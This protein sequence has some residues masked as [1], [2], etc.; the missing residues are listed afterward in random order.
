MNVLWPMAV[1]LLL[2]AARAQFEAASLKPDPG[3]SP[4]DPAD[5]TDRADQDLFVALREQI[6]A[7]GRLAGVPSGSGR[8]V[9]GLWQAA[10]KSKS[11]G[12]R[13]TPHGLQTVDS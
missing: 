2:P 13:P 6:G 8:L 5:A 12:Q 4:V 1:F 10:E 3:A 9:I 11:A 7:W